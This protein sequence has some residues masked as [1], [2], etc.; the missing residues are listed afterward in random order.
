MN[1]TEKLLLQV[2]QNAEM[3]LTSTEHLLK[4][5]KDDAVRR[6][7]SR[8]ADSYRELMDRSGNMLADMGVDRKKTPLYQRAMSSMGIEMEMMT[9]PTSANI[10]DMVIQGATMGVVELTKARHAY[11]DADPDAHAIAGDFISGQ[12]DAI[13]NM[14]AFLTFAT[15][16]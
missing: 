16:R 4:K 1:Q 13:E 14:K 5:A 6:E 10:A 8:Q 11:P 7:L 9:D 2:W 12:Q 15:A 3:G